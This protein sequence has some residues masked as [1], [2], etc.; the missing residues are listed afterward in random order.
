[1]EL[2]K[3]TEARSVDVHCSKGV[4]VRSALSFLRECYRLT[5][6]VGS[7]GTL[8]WAAPTWDPQLRKTSSNYP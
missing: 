2:S 8:L 7:F 6:I 5:G 4:I 1:M 3:R